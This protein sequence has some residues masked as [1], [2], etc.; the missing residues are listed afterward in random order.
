MQLELVLLNLLSKI[1]RRR[2]GIYIVIIIIII[3]FALGTFIPE[4]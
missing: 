3:F 4:G 2:D 1:S